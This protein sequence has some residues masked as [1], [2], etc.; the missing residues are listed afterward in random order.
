ME[1]NELELANVLDPC[2]D[3]K[4]AIPLQV[5][6][7]GAIGQWLQNRYGYSLGGKAYA[8]LLNYAR[9]EGRER[10]IVKGHLAECRVFKLL[11]PPADGTDL[12]SSSAF[13]NFTD[14]LLLE[15]SVPSAGGSSNLNTRHSARWPLTMTRSRP[16][17]E[18][19][20]FRVQTRIKYISQLQ[21]NTL[22][23]APSHT[24]YV[25]GMLHIEELSDIARRSVSS[26]LHG[27][28]GNWTLMTRVTFPA[29][30][31]SRLERDAALMHNETDIV[32]EVQFPWTMTADGTQFALLPRGWRDQVYWL[33]LERAHLDEAAY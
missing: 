31:V 1:S 17:E 10:V 7:H 20:V 2:L 22:H 4:H 29:D 15:R 28:C 14:A 8:K 32:G 26:P 9:R 5:E 6:R 16:V 25:E 3:P 19:H 18:W 23:L 21:F 13:I 11:L 27:Q 33:I 30:S 12:S 24:E